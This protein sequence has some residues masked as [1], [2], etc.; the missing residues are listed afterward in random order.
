M[1]NQGRLCT[2]RRNLHILTVNT[3]QHLLTDLVSAKIKSGFDDATKKLIALQNYSRT[4]TDQPIDLQSVE[5]MVAHCESGLHELLIKDSTL[6]LPDALSKLAEQ[7]QSADV[8][9]TFSQ[10]GDFPPQLQQHS[11]QC[12]EIAKEATGNAIKH[13]NAKSISI[14]LAVD[15]V[16]M[17]LSISDNGKGLKDGAAGH[18]MSHIERFAKSLGGHSSLHGNSQGG[19]T[20][21]LNLPLERNH[22]AKDTKTPER[23]SS[24]WWKLLPKNATRKLRDLVAGLN[25]DFPGCEAQLIASKQNQLAEVNVSELDTQQKAQLIHKLEEAANS[26]SYQSCVVHYSDTLLLVAF[27]PSST[28]LSDTE[29][30]RTVLTEKSPSILTLHKQLGQTIH[31]SYCQGLVALNM[32]TQVQLEAIPSDYDELWQHTKVFSTAVENALREARKLSHDLTDY[33]S[34]LLA[35]SPLAH[36]VMPSG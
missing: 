21:E 11:Q 9:A 30:T 2:Y 28:Q 1:A 27:Q 24:K 35:S 8:S 14:M 25:A 12:Y 19:T 13:G 3:S 10:V 29:I 33:G 15:K 4:H 36:G 20:M 26:L 34:G 22:E 5:I 6:P 17:R 23:S 31:D 7:L 16:S 18:G 32:A